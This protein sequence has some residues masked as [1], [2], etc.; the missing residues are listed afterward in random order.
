MGEHDLVAHRHAHRDSTGPMYSAGTITR[1]SLGRSA[2]PGIPHLVDAMG[3]A[4]TAPPY[5]QL[6]GDQERLDGAQVLQLGAVQE[7]LDR[8]HS[9]PARP[10]G[11]QEEPATAHSVTAIRLGSAASAA[12][13]GGEDGISRRR[14]SRNRASCP[15]GRCAAVCRGFS[16]LRASRRGYRSF[17]PPRASRAPSSTHRHRTNARLSRACIGGLRLREAGWGRERGGAE[18]RRIHPHPY[19]P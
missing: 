9:S 10:A 4:I 19:R 13:R 14:S 7:R 18:R 17:H 15:G 6:E 8:L 3:E 12:P 16:F 2:A 11:D 1:F 5:G